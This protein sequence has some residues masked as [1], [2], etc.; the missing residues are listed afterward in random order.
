VTLV[1]SLLFSCAPA[2]KAVYFNN[3]QPGKDSVQYQMLELTKRVQ[4]GDRIIINIVTQDDK[5]NQLLNSGQSMFGGMGGNIGGGQGQGMNNFGYL[6]DKAGD[7]ELPIIGKF[8]VVGRTPV[9]I[10]AMVREKVAVLYKD[11]FVTTNISG[12]V[13]ILG[14]AGIQGSVPIGNERLTVIEAVALSGV[15]DPTAHRDK[16]WVIR[17]ENGQR[18]YAQVDLNDRSIFTSPYFY[19]RN[20]DVLYAPPGKLPSFLKVNAPT[21]SVISIGTGF[22]GLL[23]SIIALSR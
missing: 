1:T 6:V 11:P 5:G 16:L 22:F 18:N 13:I 17:E 10:T 20:N 15:I 2:R 19:L 23:L 12:R 4:Y 8:S 14:D 7:I 3:L 21:L 9:E